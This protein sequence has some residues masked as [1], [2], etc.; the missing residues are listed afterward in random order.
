MDV[1][2]LLRTLDGAESRLTQLTALSARVAVELRARAAAPLAAAGE[3]SSSPAP[4]TAA[5]RATAAA[6]GLDEVARLLAA[7]ADRLRGYRG[8][9]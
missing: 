2:G 3:G 7:A 5:S 4:A 8:M 1:D 6:M 9:L